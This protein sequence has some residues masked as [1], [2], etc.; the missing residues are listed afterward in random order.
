MNICHF[1]TVHTRCDPR[2]F[3]KECISTA[4]S[5]NRVTLIVSDNKKDEEKN[6]V[7]ILSTK[8]PSKNRLLRILSIAS[9]NRIYKKAK[10]LKADIY[11]FHDPEL[12]HLGLKLKKRGFHVIYDVHEDVPRQ[13]LVKEW[14]PIFM[15]RIVS[16]LF[17]I[18]E[19]KC[20]K[21]FDAIVVPTPHIKERFIHLN[22]FVWEVCNFPP[23]GEIKYSGHKYSNQN[24]GCYV[25][26]ITS[27]RGIRQISKATDKAGIIL[28]LCGKFDS[29]GLEQEI[30]NKHRN[31]KY[32]GFL[33]RSEVFDIL[34]NSSMG[35][36]TLLDTP[37]DAAS[38]PIKLFEYMA[39]GIPVISSNFP[40]YKEI[41]EGN[42]CGICIDPLDIDAIYDAINKI[43]TDKVYAD[44]MRINGRKAIEEKYNWEGQIA[45]L[46]ECY[47]CC[48]KQPV[49]SERYQKYAGIL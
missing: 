9:R 36:V 44:E 28:Y 29:K 40:L 22:N 45:K 18:Y 42:N 43:T 20:A 30:L 32:F 13:I 6:G 8:S 33:N 46:L 37:N 3:W 21:K 7:V 34:H 5:A 47:E 12:L 15:R 17:E 4:E 27:T 10:D 1:T 2:I 49:V 25:G 11:Q 19:N 14:I 24:P 38:Y 16:G 23:V 31:I 48:L 39:A 35:F 41:V 26:G